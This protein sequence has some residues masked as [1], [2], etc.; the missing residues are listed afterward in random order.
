MKSTMKAVVMRRFGGPETL[1]LAEVPRPVPQAD[2]VL[3]RVHA[4]TVNRTLDLAV[5][6]GRYGRPVTLPH[7]LGADPVVEIGDD[8]VDRK[9]GD[10]VATSPFVKAA[11][12]SAPPVLLG[13]SAWGGYAEFVAV[14]ARITH[15]VP[16]KLDFADAAVVARHAP[17][18][19]HLLET[20][21]R[22]CPGETV[23][24][25]GASGGLGSVGVQVAKSLGATVIAGA[26]APERVARAVA[27]GADYGIDYRRSDL[28]Q[29]VMVLTGGRGVDVVFENIGDPDL[30]PQAVSSL[31]R[32]GRLVT[33]GS[34]GGGKVMLNVTELYQ[35]QLTLYGS[36]GQTSGD[37]DRALSLAADGLLQAEIADTFPLSSAARAHE[38]LEEGRIAGKIVLLPQHIEVPLSS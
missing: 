32:G 8:V 2:E 13:V 7:V 26:G 12:G 38:D 33:A 34:H 24:V 9:V 37:L 30:F 20:K 19:L 35:K 10:R 22:V 23:L 31:A 1:E 17:L 15:L 28:V 18:A 27:A 3:I 29:E 25:M 4:V 16:P 11:T 14:P 6:A 21:A 5:R 36:T